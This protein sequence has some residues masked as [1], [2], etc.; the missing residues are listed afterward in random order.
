MYACE[1][2]YVCVYV[3]THTRKHTQS[4]RY[5]RSTNTTFNDRLMTFVA[6]C[7]FVCQMI[8]FHPTLVYPE[9]LMAYRRR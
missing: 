6:H 8:V 3:C 7:A 1:R 4:S 5:N 2:V 9:Y